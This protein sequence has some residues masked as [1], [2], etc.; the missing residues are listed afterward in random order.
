MLVYGNPLGL[1]DFFGEIYIYAFSDTLKCVL[2]S[3]RKIY[4]NQKLFPIYVT[5]GIVA[6]LYV[7]VVS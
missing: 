6:A 5:H 7:Y 1:T 3:I 4:S 2:L